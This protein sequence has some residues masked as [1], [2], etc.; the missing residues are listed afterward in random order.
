MPTTA[1]EDVDEVSAIDRPDLARWL[2][3]VGVM[4]FGLTPLGLILGGS[5]G[6]MLTNAVLSFVW[7]ASVVW[8]LAQQGSLGS[9]SLWPSAMMVMAWP[10]LG[11]VLGIIR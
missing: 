7:L 6:A 1:D 2:R 4:A 5:H 3:A 8:V 11:A 9:A 10:G